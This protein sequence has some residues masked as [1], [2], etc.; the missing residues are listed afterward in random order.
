MK[1]KKIELKNFRQYFGI[2][3]LEIANQNKEKNITLIHAENGVGK[4]ALL[5]SILWCF[6]NQTTEK[7]ENKS[8]ILNYEAEKQGAKDFYVK[9]LIEHNNFDFE[10]SRGQDSL[11]AL[12]FNIHKIENGK[13]IP[14][15][16]PT[17]L[18]DSIMPWDIAVYFFFDGE[19]AETFASEKNKKN[20]AEAIENMIGCNVANVGVSDLKIII[21][22]YTEQ[23]NQLVNLDKSGQ[24]FLKQFENIENELKEKENKL[25]E[26]KLEIEMVVSKREA[27]ADSLRN[28]RAA[29]EIQIQRESLENELKITKENKCREEAEKCKWIEEYGLDLL[30]RD[31]FKKT[32]PVLEKNKSDGKLPGSIAERL[33]KE[34]ITDMK[35][36][37]KRHFTQDSEEHKELLKLL[38]TSN[39]NISIERAYR[40]NA[41]LPIVN[42][43]N[44]KGMAKLT[45]L[46]NRIVDINFKIDELESKIGECSNKLKGLN[47]EE[48]SE[49]EFKLEEKNKELNQLNIKLGK[50]EN[51]IIICND[52]VDKSKS[53]IAHTMSSNKEA[54]NIKTKIDFLENA[55]KTL[56][57]KIESYKNEARVKI[58]EEINSLLLANFKKDFV[59]KIEDNFRLKLFNKYDQLIGKSGGENQLLSLIFICAL[60]KFSIKKA[61]TLENLIVPNTIAPLVLD[62]PFGQ[63]DRAYSQAVA[64][65][66]PKMTEQVLLLVSSSQGDR[67]M[68]ASLE[69]HIGSEFVLISH[70]TGSKGDKSNDYLTASNGKKIIATK[71]NQ[72]IN[73]T[74]LE[75]I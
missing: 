60:I 43:N 12:Y 53:R 57:N 67:E 27:I 10:I 61:S 71:Y 14:I 31:L 7:F 29:K 22:K 54:S 25:I 66:L 69:N 6:Y 30:A 38:K 8:I 4:T 74:I 44:N 48:I 21:K 36:I 37:C 41:K 62:S 17:V 72:E 50:L 64:L 39:S 47:L 51:E 75:K 16:D 40:L 19:H 2:Q 5:N 20:V 23:Y 18:I 63:L 52:K 1:L 68:I 15:K 32:I 26:I 9:I 46:K 13:Y 42:E 3:V 11:G 45:N 24:E 56:E 59:V 70:T 34:L 73:K 35:C 28:T 65:M 55:K 49:K 33:L 58:Q